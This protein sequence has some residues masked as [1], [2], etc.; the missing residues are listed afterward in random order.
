MVYSNSYEGTISAIV[1]KKCIQCHGPDLQYKNIDL[2]VWESKDSSRSTYQNMVIFG[3]C[4]VF[5][6]T[7]HQPTETS[8]TQE[9]LAHFQN[10]SLPESPR[11]PEKLHHYQPPESCDISSIP[12]SSIK[13]LSGKQIQKTL[14]SYVGLVAFHNTM[15]AKFRVIFDLMPNDNNL[16]GADIGNS[17][18]D[19]SSAHVETQL[20]VAKFLGISITQQLYREQQWGRIYGGCMPQDSSPSDECLSS[21]IS[22]WGT[23]MYKR[24]LGSR[25]NR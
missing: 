15:P 2:S 17:Y 4:K 10:G 9:K 1:E 11:P 19:V 24:P 18:E 3:F 12:R 22:R 5:Q 25:G 14:L 8:L 21:F 23:R 20:I 7:C 16:A 6:K 13:R